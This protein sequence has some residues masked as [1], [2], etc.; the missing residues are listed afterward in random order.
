MTT[1]IRRAVLGQQHGTGQVDRQRTIPT[2]EIERLQRRGV[3]IGDSCIAHQRIEAAYLEALALM[4]QPLAP[5]PEE[6][7]IL[8]ETL[9]QIDGLLDGLPLRIR[10]AFLYSQLDGLRHGEIAERLGL[11]VPTVKRYIAKALEQCCFA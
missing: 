5:S 8:I 10:Q 9:V 7:A 3:R 6:Q 1:Q 2:L 4:P 11:S